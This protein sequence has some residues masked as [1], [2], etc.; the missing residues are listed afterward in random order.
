MCLDEADRMVDMGFEEDIR[1]VLSFFK[2][3]RQVAMFRCAWGSGPMACGTRASGRCCPS[4]R[5][6]ARCTGSVVGV[7]FEEGIREVLSFWKGQR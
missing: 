5:A 3:Q 7:D 2:G 1:E 6:S 4:T